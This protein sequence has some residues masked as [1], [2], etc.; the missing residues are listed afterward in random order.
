[1]IT[2]YLIR[3]ASVLALLTSLSAAN[4]IAADKTE[5]NTSA[6]YP[7]I[8]G[9]LGLEVGDDLTYRSTDPANEL[10]DLFFT[11]ELAVKFALA[12]WLAINVG[13][14]M[15]SV[16]DPTGDRTFGDIGLYADTL[17][18]E[19]S[20]ENLTIVG[21]KF[22]PGFGTAWDVTPGIYG[23][24]FAE[25]YELS[26][27]LGFGFS[28]SI[29]GTSIGTIA[30]GANVFFADTT[31]FSES[32]FTNRGR[33]RL[34]DGGAG[35]TEKFDNFSLTFDVSDIP[36]AE[37]MALHIGYR[38][39]S[40]GVGDISDEN[41]LAAGFSHESELS[42]GM[43]LGLN[44]EVAYFDGFG[45]SGD[46]VLYA[47]AGL[48]LVSGPWHGE[49]AGSARNTHSF[50]GGSVHDQLVKVSAG[51]EFE[52]GIDLSIGYKFDTDAGTRNHTVGFRLSKA[53]EFS[54]K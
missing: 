2:D 21:G 22:G 46:D 19:I 31:I 18:A 29:E 42:N 6:N 4:V 34:A 36:N 14:T 23:A 48:S 53:I 8:E 27:L 30:L 45:G 11:G 33:T 39:L 13:L 9:E 5:E 1:M 35:N 44:G 37:G 47:M 40:A 3:T 7:Y 20:I 41:G 26:E 52:N 38:H 43:T 51:Y 15:E 50:G 49:L 17:N 12:E 28:Y 16:L 24:D 25:D 10:N 32:A 54:T